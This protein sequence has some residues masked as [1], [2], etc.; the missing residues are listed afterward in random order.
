MIKL[1]FD[2]K[3]YEKGTLHDFGCVINKHLVEKGWAQW[4][5]VEDV[6]MRIK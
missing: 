3:G 2:F 1:L 4:I 5:K 6:K